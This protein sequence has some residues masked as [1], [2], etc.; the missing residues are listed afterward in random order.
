V[1]ASFDQ[2]LTVETAERR[3]HGVASFAHP[4]R[5]FGLARALSPSRKPQHRPQDHRVE[6]HEATLTVY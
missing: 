2:P 5:Y 6:V 3:P 4:E 1:R